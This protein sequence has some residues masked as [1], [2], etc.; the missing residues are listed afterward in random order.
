MEIAK[1]DKIGIKGETGSGK[2]SLINILLGLI[3]VKKEKLYGKLYSL[4]RFE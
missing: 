1:G 2:T 4:I 3:S